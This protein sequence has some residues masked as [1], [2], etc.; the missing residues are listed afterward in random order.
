MRFSGN[1]SQGA[2]V[3]KK[4]RQS[5]RE[6]ILERFRLRQPRKGMRERGKS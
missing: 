2:T 5:G 1:R 4:S 6:E 3:P